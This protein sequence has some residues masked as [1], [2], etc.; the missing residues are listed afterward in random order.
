MAMIIITAFNVTSV[1]FQR[2]LG[3]EVVT[4]DKDVSL[5]D[6]IA[7]QAIHGAVWARINNLMA[8]QDIEGKRSTSSC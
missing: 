5:A 2:K 3:N 4:H 8:G 6:F 1:V 7:N